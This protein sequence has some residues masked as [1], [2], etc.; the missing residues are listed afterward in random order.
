MQIIHDGSNAAEY[1]CKGIDRCDYEHMKKRK[2]TENT[3][4]HDSEQSNNVC[5]IATTE[6][7][8]L[9]WLK[10]QVDQFEKNGQ[11]SEQYRD[12]NLERHPSELQQLCIVIL[13]YYKDS[14]IN[15]RYIRRMLD[16]GNPV[17]KVRKMVLVEQ[18]ESDTIL[19]IE[20]SYDHGYRFKKLSGHYKKA[21][22][23]V[24]MFMET[25]CVNSAVSKDSD[26]KKVTR[27]YFMGKTRRKAYANRSVVE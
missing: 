5:L 11:N 15:E 7:P 3:P 16:R 18:I 25:Q 6:K 12:Q 23:Q 1:F 22:K 4:D 8:S 13:D 27:R 10:A 9:D 26:K 19:R 17:P 14:M 21:L 20:D 24:M 2:I